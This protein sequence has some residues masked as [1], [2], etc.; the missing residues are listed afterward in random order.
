MLLKLGVVPGTKHIIL[1]K[2]GKATQIP[3]VTG[4]TL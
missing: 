2:I 1:Q 4:K 3:K